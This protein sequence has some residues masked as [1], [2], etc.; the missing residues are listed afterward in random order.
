MTSQTYGKTFS[1]FSSEQK[2]VAAVK[3][4]HHCVVFLLST[5][6]SESFILDSLFSPHQIMGMAAVENVYSVMEELPSFGP[7]GVGLN[8]GVIM[9]NITRMRGL[10]GGGL[11]GAVRQRQYNELL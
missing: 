7:P 5:N 1:E 10:S 9:M 3:L 2:A 11:T 8:A 6:F 4:I